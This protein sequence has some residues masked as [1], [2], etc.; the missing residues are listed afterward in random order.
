MLPFSV[1]MVLKPPTVMCR[2]FLFVFNWRFCIILICQFKSFLQYRF[3]ISHYFEVSCIPFSFPP[4]PPAK[5]YLFN[6][7]LRLVVVLFIFSFLVHG[8]RAIFRWL[9]L[10]KKKVLPN[11]FLQALK[12]FGRCGGEK[13]N[14]LIF[15]GDF[16]G[17]MLA[18]L[19]FCIK[20]YP[21]KWALYC[22][23]DFWEGLKMLSRIKINSNDASWHITCISDHTYFPISPDT[24]QQINIG[25]L[26]R[27]GRKRWTA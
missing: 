24:T 27:V 5:I 18:M 19:T 8:I 16:P 9:T 26:W 10:F 23:L 13:R 25:R 12:M 6:Y 4:T 1:G 22:Q 2:A 11:Q 20:F 17:N 14:V 15:L 21:H 3:L 7:V